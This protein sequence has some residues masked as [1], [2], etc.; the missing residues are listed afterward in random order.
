MVNEHCSSWG[1]VA[2]IFD[3]SLCKLWSSVA[4]VTLWIDSPV[5]VKMMDNQDVL[6][7]PLLRCPWVPPSSCTML[8]LRF[9]RRPSLISF[10]IVCGLLWLELHCG[11]TVQV[12]MWMSYKFLISICRNLIL[13]HVPSR[14]MVAAIFDSTSIV[15]GLLWLEFHCAWNNSPE[16]VMTVDVQYVLGLQLQKHNSS[17]CTILSLA[18]IF[19]KY[20]NNL[21]SSVA[22]VAVEW[23]T[24]PDSY[25]GCSRCFQDGL[26]FSL[27]WFSAASCDIYPK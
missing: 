3:K 19:D 2:T 4:C 17:S 25:V 23:Y 7:I 26:E 5:L 6:G 10:S 15:Y 16:Q 9:G 11:V 8:I 22:W 18:A 21:W 12:M 13:L 1:L 27:Y 24:C 20:L 14:G